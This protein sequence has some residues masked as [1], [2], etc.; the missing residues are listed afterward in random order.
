M[1]DA[2]KALNAYVVGGEISDF[3]AIPFEQKLTLLQVTPDKYIKEREVAKKI[4]KYVEHTYSKKA[5]NFVFNF[6]VTNEVIKEE[7][8]EY[9]EDFRNYYHKDC[10]KDNQGKTIPVWDKRKVIEA[11]VTMKFVMGGKIT[12]TVKASHKG[13]TN[14][15]TTRANI[16]EAAYSKAWTKVAATF[17]IGAELDRVDEM[18]AYEEPEVVEVEVQEQPSKSFNY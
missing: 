17:G 3:A 12:R 16:M 4:F 9:V 14:P 7:Y 18:R 1:E 6:D 5:L 13:Y 11:E 15:A 2:K 8:N 10:K